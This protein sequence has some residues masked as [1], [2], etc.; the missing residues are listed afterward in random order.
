MDDFL[1]FYSDTKT[2]IHR[3]WESSSI[4]IT[5]HISIKVLLEKCVS[6]EDLQAKAKEPF[7]EE[8]DMCDVIEDKIHVEF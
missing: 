7:T 8:S 2:A 4:A 1:S 5:N 6:F 3:L